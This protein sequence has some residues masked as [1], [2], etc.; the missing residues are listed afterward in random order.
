MLILIGILSFA[1]VQPLLFR[2]PESVGLLA[3]GAGLTT[4][5]VITRR[6]ISCGNAEKSEVNGAN[7]LGLV[8]RGSNDEC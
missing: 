4:T 2:M 1:A 5:A 3:F 6:F 8:A 7:S